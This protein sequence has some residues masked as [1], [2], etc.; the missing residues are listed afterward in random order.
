MANARGFG[1]GQGHEG[2]IPDPPLTPEDMINYLKLI[3]DKYNVPGTLNA[4]PF[5]LTANETI[6]VVCMPSR[7]NS[8]I[9]TVI[10]GTVYIYL[11]DYSVMN[12]KAPA[13][14]HISVSAGVV[15]TTQQFA[16]PDSSEYIFTVQEAVAAT[17]AGCIIPLAV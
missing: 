15:P 3:S 14:P 2:M 4:V 7:I 9:V 5:D 6:R 11:G 1:T 16:L 17:A 10:S 8:L 12:G 13:P